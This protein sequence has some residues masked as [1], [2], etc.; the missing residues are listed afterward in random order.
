MLPAIALIAAT[1]TATAGS[2]PATVNIGIGPTMSWLGAPGEAPLSRSV[3][4]AL[5]AE[6]WVSKKTLRSRKVK[7]RVPKQYRGMLKGMPDAH[8]TP[9][10]VMLIPDLVGIAPLRAEGETAPSVV[11]TSWSPLSLSLIHETKGPHMV[12][13]VQPRVSWLRLEDSAGTKTNAAW[14]GASVQ[15]EIQTHMKKRVGVAVGG[16]VGG[17][18]VPEP[19]TTLVDYAAPWLHTD[20]YAR[21][22]LR[23][24]IDVDL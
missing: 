22:Q 3:G 5:L 6:G 8:V 2:I 23:F 9:L 11:P 4:V 1:T 7:K 13:D 19:K 16:H 18:W 10:P 14:L 15:P 12:F 24:P 21:L 20:A 17:G